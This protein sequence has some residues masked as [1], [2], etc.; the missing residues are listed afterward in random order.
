[1]WSTSSEVTEPLAVLLNLAPI[2]PEQFSALAAQVPDGGVVVDTTVWMPAPSGEARGVRGI[3]LYVR[4]SRGLCASWRESH[5]L[6]LTC[7]NA[8]IHT[9]KRKSTTSPSAMT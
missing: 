2:A 1:M 9:L 6:P 5:P 3:D 8:R 7:A 4:N